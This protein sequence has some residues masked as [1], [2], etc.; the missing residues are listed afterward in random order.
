MNVFTPI[1]KK[2]TAD[3]N[4]CIIPGNIGTFS[5]SFLADLPKSAVVDHI[6]VDGKFLE[7]VNTKKIRYHLE[8]DEKVKDNTW[9][10]VASV[11]FEDYDLELYDKLANHVV[12]DFE[13]YYHLEA[14]V[15]A[16]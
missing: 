9:R 2:I 11:E 10:V 14:V 12:Q 3:E 13:V 8:S 1:K 5:I 6:K 16:D 7:D 4:G 15:E